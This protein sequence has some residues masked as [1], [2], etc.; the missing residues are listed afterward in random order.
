MSPISSRNSVPPAAAVERAGEGAAL[1]AEQLA[2]DQLAR[3]GGHVDG[4]EGAGA[5]AAVIVQ[6]AGDQLLAG[7]G[8]AVDHDG[9]VRGREPGD[10]AV[11]LLHRDRAADQRQALLVIRALALGGG[12]DGR[13]RGQGTA[14]NGEKFF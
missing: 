14:D 13:G 2:L 10:A 1:V 12:I 3:D 4:D 11:D 8:F 6:R 7:A 9:Q 5:A